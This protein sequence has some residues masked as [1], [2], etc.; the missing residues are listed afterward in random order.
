MSRRGNCY[1]D[2]VMEASFSTV[3]SELG[4]RFASHADAKAQ[5]LDY[6]AVFCNQR[7]SAAG[8]MSPAALERRMTQ[9]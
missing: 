2:A 4:E 7:H 6:L 5:L 1:D 3:K 8:R 9:A